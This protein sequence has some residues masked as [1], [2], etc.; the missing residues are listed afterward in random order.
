MDDLLLSDYRRYGRQMIIDGFGLP[1][2]NMAGQLKLYK[3]AVVIVGAGGLG[4]PSLQYLAAA[5]VG[6]IGVID[7][8][9]VEMS[10]LQRQ[11]LHTEHTVGMYKTE[12]AAQVVK[13]LNSRVGVETINEPLLPTNATRLLESYDIIL[14]CTDNAPARYLLNDTAVRLGKPLVSGAAQRYYGQVC[15]YNL[16]EEG[17]CYRCLFPNPPRL[18]ETCEE[19]GI[20]GAVA[21]I[22]GTLQALE[23]IKIITGLHVTSSDMKPQLLT[24]SVIRSPAFYSLPL[25]PRNPSCPSCG[26]EGESIG[27]IRDIDYVQFCG[28]PTPDWEREGMVNPGREYRITVKDLKNRLDRNPTADIIDVR[29][30]TQFGICHL[31]KSRNLNQDVPLDK[32]KSEP[33]NYLPEGENVE[34]Y[35]ICRL[36]NDSQIAANALR[37]YASST[38]NA[39]YVIKDIIGGLKAWSRDIDKCFPVYQK[40]YPI[41]GKTWLQERV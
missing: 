21:G 28:G 2:E 20:L 12:S 25:A 11:I 18:R 7:H 31:P 22:I 36:G 37:G 27:E 8:D 32:F 38:K 4:C 29:S 41:V 26:K 33:G 19:T 35:F 15:T 30:E 24:F 5:G 17:L 16:G 23:A 1:D 14:D 3:A 9:T 13:K 34:I 40:N 6:R 39:K 10:N